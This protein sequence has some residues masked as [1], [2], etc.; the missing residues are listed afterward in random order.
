MSEAIEG[1]KTLD[2]FFPAHTKPAARV[3]RPSVASLIG[4]ELQP[5]IGAVRS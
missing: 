2:R 1:S 5:W 3:A 4:I